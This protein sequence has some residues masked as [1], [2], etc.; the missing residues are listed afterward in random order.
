MRSLR[1]RLALLWVLSFAASLAV[2]VLLVSLYRQ[3]AAAQAGRAEAVAARTCDMVVERWSFYAAGWAGP[4][5]ARRRCRLP[6]RPDD[7]LAIALPPAQLL[8]AGVWRAERGRARQ[9]SATTR[10]SCE[11]AIA[12]AA[13]DALAEDRTATTRTGSARDP[14]GLAA[15]PLAGPVSGLV[16]YVAVPLFGLPGLGALQAALACCSP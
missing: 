1:S 3:S 9:P 11:S 4:G 6:P 10:P 13:A 14:V 7:L 5:P 8:R 16:A 15:C 2:G 12:E